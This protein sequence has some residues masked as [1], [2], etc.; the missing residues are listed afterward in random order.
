M[1]YLSLLQMR[2]SSH[3]DILEMSRKFTFPKEKLGKMYYK[4]MDLKLKCQE[5][6]T[7]LFI[8][9]NK[10]YF[11]FSCNSICLCSFSPPIF[12]THY[13]EFYR[14]KSSSPFLKPFWTFSELKEKCKENIEG[15][16]AGGLK[17][18]QT[19]RMLKILGVWAIRII[20]ILKN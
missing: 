9:T 11:N 18:Q 13:R 20:F 4:T 1:K 17:I 7:L 8:S 10:E 6:L 3:L 2:V 12:I 15:G 19:F 14:H 5:N 16:G